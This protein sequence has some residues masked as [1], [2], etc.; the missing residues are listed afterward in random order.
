[1]QQIYRGEDLA[2]SETPQSFQVWL[3][4]TLRAPNTEAGLVSSHVARRLLTM[5]LPKRRDVANAMMRLE[6]WDPFDRLNSG[7]RSAQRLTR[8][9]ILLALRSAP[10]S[11][12]LYLAAAWLESLTDGF[13]ARGQALLEASHVFAPREFVVIKG[14]LILGGRVWPLLS[15]EQR[16][17][18][19]AD[20]A[21]FRSVDA[22][23]AA[24][25]EK[26]LAQEGMTLQ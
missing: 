20:L 1:L 6:F 18:L 25:F 17:A 15:P 4:E 11:G 10:T 22:P 26:R 3:F 9:G 7:Q 12:D 2:V 19:Q 13:G 24:E 21:I 16:K 8:D 23:G 5:P 14:R